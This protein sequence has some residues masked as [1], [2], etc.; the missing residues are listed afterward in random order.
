MK[1]I[2]QRIEE[3]KRFM[4]EASQKHVEA[5]QVAEFWRNQLVAR[6]GQLALLTDMEKEL[7][8]E[9]TADQVAMEALNESGSKDSAPNGGGATDSAGSSIKNPSGA[10]AEPA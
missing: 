8:A 3:T 1:T 2:R 9:S 5:Q 10:K 7:S 6:E 4:D